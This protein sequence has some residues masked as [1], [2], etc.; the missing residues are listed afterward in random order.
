MVS[1]NKRYILW[2]YVLNLALAFFGTAAF[3]NQAHEVL[4][5]SLLSDRLV[6]GLD[7]T[8]FFEMLARPE[9]GPMKAA[10]AS[11]SDLALLFFVFTALFLPGVLM[12]YASTYRL[13][14]GDF[15][16]ACGRNLWRFV[17]LMIVAAVVMGIAAA[18]LFSI[19]IPLMKAADTSTNELMSFYMSLV[20]LAVIFLI[21]CALRIWF[22]I[23]QADVVLSDQKAV[24]RSIARAFRHTMRHLGRLLG[25]YVISTLVAAVILAAGIFV[26]IKFVPAASVFGAMLVSQF[27]LLLLLIP[28]FWQRGVAVS[29]YLQYMVEPI[30]VQQFAPAP[31]AAPA[32]VETRPIQVVPGSN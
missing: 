27:T 11:A 29:Y 24:R 6:H 18:A 20:T 14:G 25:S 28:R 16:R 17:R 30:P 9:F 31:V 19:R 8:V 21:M 22:D 23:A 32:V 1:R 13:P 4:D 10:T 12:G 3:S 7:A 26:W 5:H 15:F 2:F